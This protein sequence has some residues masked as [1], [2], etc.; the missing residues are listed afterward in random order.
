MRLRRTP[1]WPE[2]IGIETFL[3]W[4]GV[5]IPVLL[6]VGFVRKSATA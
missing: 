3:P 5:L 4:L 1:G 6:V 2:P